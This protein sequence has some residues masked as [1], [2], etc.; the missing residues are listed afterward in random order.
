MFALCKNGTILR[1][2][3]G[4][5]WVNRQENEEKTAAMKNGSKTGKKQRYYRLFYRSF[6]RCDPE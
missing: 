5:L 3:I 1:N 2:F 4:V 6:I